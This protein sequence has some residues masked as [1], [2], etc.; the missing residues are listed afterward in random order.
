MKHKPVLGIDTSGA[1]LGMAVR[2]SD[3]SVKSLSRKGI[4]QEKHLF[5]MMD[6]L[7]RPRGVK[8]AD[9]SAVCVLTG[10]GRFTGIRVG[11]TLASVLESLAGVRA[12]GVSAL[13]V[14]ARQAVESGDF[15]KTAASGKKMRIASIV[16]AFRE[17]YYCQIFKPA[18]WP[19]LVKPAGRA[20]W[21]TAEKMLDYLKSLGPDLYC[22]GEAGEGRRLA[23]IIPPGLKTA[24][25]VACRIM[26][27]KI[28]SA[29]LVRKK[30]SKPVPIYL[31]PA[32]YE[33]MK[34]ATE[35]KQEKQ[36]T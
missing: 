23:E 32:R 19:E 27:C 10:P 22:V 28:I 5:K 31:K 15:R 11:L 1:R 36:A 34:K 2:F 13:E 8:L 29:G 26:P 4:N 9:L 25:P 21:L 33:L 30:P 12:I 6:S 24:P 3:G 16:H 18:R 35:A 14:L 17:E 20:M 7:M